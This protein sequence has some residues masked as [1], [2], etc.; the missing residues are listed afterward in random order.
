MRPW[1]TRA[2]GWALLETERLLRAGRQQMA[3]EGCH[4]R[5]NHLAAY[6]GRVDAALQARMG[7]PRERVR[8][9]DAR[10]KELR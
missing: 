1:D 2:A 8:L 3:L 10:G 9:L 6:L 7:M 5:V 4:V